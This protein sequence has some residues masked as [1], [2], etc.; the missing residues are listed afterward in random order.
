VDADLN[1]T[2]TTVPLGGS[3]MEEDLTSEHSR[4]HDQSKNAELVQ[5]HNLIGH[6][7]QL[8]GQGRQQYHVVSTSVF[9]VL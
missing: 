4:E 9:I 2:L 6:S 5:V 1:G 3:A 7:L 8:R